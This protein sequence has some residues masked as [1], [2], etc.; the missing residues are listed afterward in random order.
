MPKL[1]HLRKQEP[2]K[3]EGILEGISRTVAGMVRESFADDV[4]RNSQGLGAL[5][6][7]LDA[8]SPAFDEQLNKLASYIVYEVGRK[9]EPQLKELT[10]EL[11]S[12]AI[13]Q[14]DMVKLQGDLVKALS[15]VRIPDYSEQLRR[16]DVKPDLGPLLEKLDNLEVELPVDDRPLQWTFDIKRD[17]NGLLESVT[18]T[19]QD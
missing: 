8:L 10:K 15:N 1:A 12:R 17:R 16:L 2:V 9:V 11:K 3:I 4:A 14:A 5:Q 7:R 13:T 18:A 19:A 6:E